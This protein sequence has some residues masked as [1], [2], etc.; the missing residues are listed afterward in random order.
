MSDVEEQLAQQQQE[1][2]NAD[3]LNEM[4]QRERN[5]REQAPPEHMQRP[6]QL[7]AAKEY[8]QKAAGRAVRRYGAKVAGK[9]AARYG[10]T[11]VLTAS[12]P[13]WGTILGVF[14][15]AMFIIIVLVSACNTTSGWLINL[16]AKIVTFGQLDVCGPFK[17]PN[18]V[19]PAVSGTQPLPG[20]PDDLIYL[21]TLGIPVKSDIDDRARK[22]MANKV[23]K[24]YEQSQGQGLNWEITSA[25]RPGAVTSE[26]K[27]SAHS[28]GEAVDIVLRPAPA[29]PWSANQKIKDLVALA[30]SLGFE[31]PNGDTLDEYNKPTEY[32][33]AAHIHIEFNRANQQ[34]YCDTTI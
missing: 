13:I 12:A 34:I 29:K 18:V 22:C 4:N 16:G 21:S 28:R 33:T 24:L 20:E 7:D 3:K 26:G 19:P 9:A 25:F 11:A 1:Q 27:P 10:V 31:P 30:K 15:A 5:S 14:A 8:A 32:A 2:A 23:K 6:G 17:L